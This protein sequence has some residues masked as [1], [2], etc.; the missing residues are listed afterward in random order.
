MR[1]QRC[2][3]DT[4]AHVQ[5]R[6]TPSGK[7]YFPMGWFTVSQCLGLSL[8]AH[9]RPASN[10]SL[11]HNSFHL[12]V[13]V[14]MYSM[15]Q[16]ST[17]FFLEVKAAEIMVCKPGSSSLTEPMWFNVLCCKNRSPWTVVRRRR[18][19]GKTGLYSTPRPPLNNSVRAQCYHSTGRF[20]IPVRTGLK[21]RKENHVWVIS[22]P[23]ENYRTANVSL[24]IS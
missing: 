5:Y 22:Q 15:L 19:G 8:S 13:W 1:S 6:H 4:E 18:N 24:V 20:S 17:V 21:R 7:Y 14:N 2:H 16:A 11:F 9:F 23:E 10:L 12:L 3:A